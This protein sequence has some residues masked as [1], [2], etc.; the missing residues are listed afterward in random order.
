MSPDTRTPNSVASPPRAVPN[1]IAAT[2]FDGNSARRTEVS[3]VLAGRTVHVVD[4]AGVTVAHVPRDLVRV[5]DRIGDAPYRIAFPNGALA[6]THA[7][8]AIERAF[9]LS[10]GSHWLAKMERA[11][12]V[13]VS[14]MI[15][16]AAALGFAYIKVVP[17]AAEAISHRIPR[18]AEK[19]LGNISLKGLDG[20]LLKPTQLSTEEKVTTW[21]A[22]EQLS[23]AAGL[24]GEVAIE[25]RAMM[26]NALALPGG[27]IV[28]TD[29]LVKL[30]QGKEPMIA[31]VLAHE[32]GHIH[33]RHSMRHLLE[34]SA[35][36]MIVG[37][38]AGDVS[39]VSA[40]VTAAPVIL[41]T[42]HYTRESER[43]ADEYAFALLQKIG[44]SPNDFADAMRRFQDMEL[45]VALRAED[46]SSDGKRRRKQ[47][48]ASESD[49]DDGYS[50]ASAEDSAAD[51]KDGKARCFTEPEKYLY[52][53]EAAVERL[54]REDRETGYMHTHP[55]T[56]ERIRAAEAAAKAVQ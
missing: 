45:C 47:N 17:V 56:Q 16:L 26:P 31:A 50:A 37:A 22:F 4:A 42:L 46:R 38:L 12:W 29:G 30:F 9:R 55:V 52:G 5:S 20:F 27:T 18:D 6:V 21:R 39:G 51:S 11:R 15:G 3:L 13:V 53:R 43:E 54:K 34:G 2:W 25:N 1:G 49:D 32:L 41:S 35:S 24:K 10:P 48:N 36:A 28:V 19:T 40:L 8:A 7:H 14:A 44:R 33:H 23:Q